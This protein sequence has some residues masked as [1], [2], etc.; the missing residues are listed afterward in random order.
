MQN[1]VEWHAQWI[2]ADAE[3]PARNAF[4]GFRRSFDYSGGQALLHLTA[5]S[6]YT[7]FLNGKRLGQGPVRA[8]P[9]HWRYDSYDLTS[10]LHQG[11]NTLAVLINH[12]GEGNFQ[13]L[14][15]PPG[16]LLQLELGGETLLS[17]ASWRAR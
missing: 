7:L 11:R 8:W 1:A 3:L 5:D 2:W 9:N 13:Y 6:R 16:L 17:D 12:W 10:D 14:P 4:V 15:A